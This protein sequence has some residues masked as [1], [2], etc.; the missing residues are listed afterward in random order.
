MALVFGVIAASISAG[1]VR[2]RIDVDEHR[3]APQ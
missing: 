1:S 3:S 2:G